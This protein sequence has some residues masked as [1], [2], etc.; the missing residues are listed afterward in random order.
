MSPMSEDMRSG[1]PRREA[2]RALVALP[3]G[4]TAGALTLTL[5]RQGFAVD[6]LED[7]EEGARLLEQG[8][9]NLAATA[10]VAG[11]PGKGESLYQRLNRLSSEARR[12]LFIILVGEEFK[13]GDGTQA[14][15]VLADMVIHS[16]DAGNA[17]SPLRGAL[18]ERQRLYQAYIDAKH[19]HEAAAG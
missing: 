17:D 12:R 10:R 11:A 15:T 2:G 19:R 3:N 7:W 16:R 5:T 14:F 4:A 6:T 9:Y 13:T 1:A 18:A 8:V